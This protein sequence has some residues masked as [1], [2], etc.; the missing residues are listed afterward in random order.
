[1]G[2]QRV[3]KTE[4]QTPLNPI[5]F[6]KWLPRPQEG[7]KAEWTSDP[8]GSLGKVLSYKNNLL[9]Q[10]C[11]SG[12]QPGYQALGIRNLREMEQVGRGKGGQ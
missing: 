3:P 4:S 10:G 2:E 6:T 12:K 7:K 1:M 11:P 9:R 8:W 5:C